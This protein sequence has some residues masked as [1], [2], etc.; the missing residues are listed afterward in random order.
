MS[1]GADEYGIRVS[2]VF[3][4][5]RER[6]WREWTEPARFADWYGGPLCEVPLDS[7][8]M[9]VRQGGKWRLT[10]FAPPDRRRIDWVGEYLEVLAPE[11]LVFTL[12]DQPDAD[13]FE[14]VTV[15]LT[16]LGDNRTEMLFEQRGWMSPEQYERATEGW[17]GFFDRMEERLG[18]LN[19]R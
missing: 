9:D 16:S 19:E 2:R 11:R 17:G 8:S 10:M 4:A 6:V 18:R 3:H 7:V 13:A 12:S 5:S 1:E 14:L 15:V